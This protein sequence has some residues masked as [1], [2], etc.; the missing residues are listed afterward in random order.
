MSCRAL[1]LVA[2]S[3]A[4]ALGCRRERT[5]E[6]E[7]VA[8][9]TIQSV[10]VP[11]PGTT[12]TVPFD[13]DR[14][15]ALVVAGNPEIHEPIVWL[16]G[17]CADPKADLE[18]IGTIART[19]GTILSISGDVPCPGQPGR[20]TWTDDVAS[21]DGRISLAIAAVNG[22]G[23]APFLVDGPL[24]VVGVSMGA[25]RAEALSGASPAR[26]GRLVLVGA[27]KAPSPDTLAG[28]R[29]VAMV[30]GDQEPQR[31]MRDG[32][33]ALD[34]A[35]VPSRFFLLPGAPHGSFGPDGE[36]VMSEA[37]AFVRAH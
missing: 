21:I 20:T 15:R 32:A 27:P 14:D 1:A 17:M 34:V 19:H 18:A 5:A 9:T 7:P 2:L 13:E 12:L 16:H 31:K 36:H 4:L 26:Y 37:V 25:T 6:A 3:G 22:A 30:A 8:A 29:A 10:D 35:G 33:H 24:L 28:A 11:R 23:V